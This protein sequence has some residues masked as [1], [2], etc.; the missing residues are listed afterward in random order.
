MKHAPGESHRMSGELQLA[1][2]HGH[3]AKFCADILTQ[4]K[5]DG[6]Y[7]EFFDKLMPHTQKCLYKTCDCE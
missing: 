6:N 1:H 2:C 3:I 5:L 4:W 7:W